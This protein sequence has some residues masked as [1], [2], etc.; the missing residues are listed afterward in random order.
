ML[1]Y[2]MLWLHHSIPS[3]W[4][5]QGCLKFLQTQTSFSWLAT[6]I[7]FRYI[8]L[9][10]LPLVR[11]AYKKKE[12]PKVNPLGKGISL[13]ASRPDQ[14]LWVS[15]GHLG[16][17][18]LGSVF[19]STW[20]FSPGLVVVWC[21]GEGCVRCYLRAPRIS[22]SAMSSLFRQ[23]RLRY[24]NPHYLGR[25]HTRTRRPTPGEYQKPAPEL[26]DRY[27]FIRLTSTTVL[28]KLGDFR[29]TSGGFWDRNMKFL[30][31]GVMFSRT[32]K[33]KLL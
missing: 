4:P 14:S 2:F 13:H 31:L 3:T 6:E 17:A 8:Q 16:S 24:T 18:P 21:C 33:K 25:T 26:V 22:R 7:I 10:C 32:E 11:S 30:R 28:K 12:S 27:V 20:Y 19:C 15:F 9:R 23:G 5:W 1:Q 29:I